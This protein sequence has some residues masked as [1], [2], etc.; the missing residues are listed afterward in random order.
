MG[1][2]VHPSCSVS[3]SFSFSRCDGDER[4]MTFP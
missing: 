2:E 4:D 3:F 1:E